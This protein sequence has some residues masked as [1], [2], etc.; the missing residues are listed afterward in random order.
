MTCVYRF[1]CWIKNLFL[2]VLK[3]NLQLLKWFTQMILF[4]SYC[5]CKQFFP[6]IIGNAHVRIIYKLYLIFHFSLRQSLIFWF[7]AV[8]TSANVVILFFSQLLP[9]ALIFCSK[10]IS[11]G[12]QANKFLVLLK[13]KPP[14]VATFC[15]SS[16]LV[17]QLASSK[18]Q[19]DT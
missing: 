7:T 14:S 18:E 15:R 6:F 4:C 9:F 13:L 2:I 1:W 17:F 3:K 11:A 12:K 5:G 10:A 19:K 16:W 8:D